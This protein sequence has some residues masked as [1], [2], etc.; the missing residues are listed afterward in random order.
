MH[1]I[2]KRHLTQNDFVED[3]DQ[4]ILDKIN[5]K[6]DLK[7]FRWIKRH[8]PESFMQMRQITTNYKTIRNI[9]KQRQH[10]RLHEW[11]MF[12]DAMLDQ[13]S[14]PQYIGIEKNVNE[15]QDTPK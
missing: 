5:M 1:T 11:S 10:H 7:D 13:L 3:I 9:C 6:I 12:V 2:Q 15:N 8:L 14:K 4:D